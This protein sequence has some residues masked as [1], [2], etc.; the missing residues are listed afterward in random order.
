[1]PK[2]VPARRRLKSPLTRSPFTRL[3]EEQRLAHDIRRSLGAII[4]A[5]LFGNLWSITITGP[6]LAGYAGALGANALEF[7]VLSGI[8]SAVMLLQIPLAALVSRKHKRK[9]YLL[10]YG[11]FSR[12]MWI[13]V[14][15]VPYFMPLSPAWL[16][17]W[18]VIFLVGISS[19]GL[20]LINVT[21]F[22]WLADLL[23]MGIRGRWFSLRD[24]INAITGVLIGLLTAYL[25]DT[26]PGFAGYSL[27]FIIGGV[28]GMLDMA[29]FALVKEVYPQQPVKV[30]FGRV[31]GQ[32]FRDKPFLTLSLFWMAWC[33]TANISGPYINRYVLEDMGLSFTQ[34]TVC[35][36]IAAALTAFLVI[37][38]WGRLLDRYGSKPVL[39]V[40]C[41]IA[42]LT[43]VFFCFSVPGNVLPTL[44]HNIIGAAF[45]SAAN[46]TV[47]SM[48]LSHSPDDLR[49][50]Y[51]AVFSCM[52]SLGGVF[53]GTLFGGVMIEGIRAM[54]AARSL[55][56]L[57]M[58]LDP[59]KI[60]FFFSVISRLAIVLI[61]IPKMD[62]EKG[63]AA[64]QM[65]GEV[66]RSMRPV[67]PPKKS[68]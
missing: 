22:P 21:W 18:S 1:M 56:F 43:P 57:G 38:R 5:N 13:I 2:R 45:W 67:R 37:P 15:L 7:G 32:I 26:I 36:Q 53:L 27:V 68:A 62:N 19:C 49:P 55:S 48:Q 46:L 16:R 4:V 25:L 52:A 47:T 64:R 29:S 42:S 20:A 44:L 9:K 41:I 8:P 24:A 33:F 51:I 54:T 35:G 39:W 31:I 14:G 58:A 30:R 3:Y 10:T 28:L 66:A 65:I 12:M 61:F 59:Y 40:S 11:L 50:S 60:T 6:A 23:P 34:L 63:V 17:L